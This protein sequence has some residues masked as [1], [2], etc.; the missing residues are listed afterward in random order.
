MFCLLTYLKVHLRPFIHFTC[1]PCLIRLTD[2]LNF[3]SS[4]CQN[5]PSPDWWKHGFS[6][7]VSWRVQNSWY[8]PIGVLFLQGD[9]SKTLDFQN[10][11]QGLRS[12]LEV[13]HLSTVSVLPYVRSIILRDCLVQMIDWRLQTNHCVLHKWTIFHQSP[14][15]CRL[16]ACSVLAAA[17][18]P[19][20]TNVI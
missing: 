11:Y 10:N 2:G 5:I 13:F 16:P 12:A 19:C 18:F 17:S 4:A 7:H 15:L 1:Y 9:W 3:L 8:L 20:W 6:S 14:D